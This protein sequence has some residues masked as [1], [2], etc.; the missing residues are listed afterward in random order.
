M[1]DVSTFASPTQAELPSQSMEKYR[2]ASYEVDWNPV[3]VTYLVPALHRGI[4][5][6]D[7]E[8]LRSDTVQQLTERRLYGIT[9]S[10]NTGALETSLVSGLRYR[11]IDEQLVNFV[12]RIERVLEVAS[13]E[14][15][16]AQVTPDPQYVS[17]T[18]LRDLQRISS[19]EPGEAVAAY[20]DALEDEVQRTH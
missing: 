12:K 9:G 18:W 15:E 16:E 17:S 4:L 20:Y 10:R 14:A 19:R 11:L 3:S 6:H 1:S 8:H 7:L 5:W 2:T 13:E